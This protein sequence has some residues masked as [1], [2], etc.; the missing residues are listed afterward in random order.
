MKILCGTDI[1]EIERIKKAVDE[2]GEAFKRKVFTDYEVDYCEN[3]KAAKYKSYAAR[4]AAKEAVSK[5]FGTGIANGLSLR[6]IE[7]RNDLSGKPFAVLYGKAKDFYSSLNSSSM[8]ISLSHCDN[9]AVA[10][11]S[12]ITAQ[13]A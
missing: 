2:L 7:I 8:D 9:Y 1:V 13:D 6:E 11:V 12:I 3:R 5:A 4:F 10:Y